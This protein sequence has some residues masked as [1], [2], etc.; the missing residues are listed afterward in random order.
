YKALPEKHHFKFLTFI[1]S[2]DIADLVMELEPDMQKEV[3]QK[4]GIEKSSK[5]MDIMDNDDLADLLSEIS[6]EKLEEYLSAMQT[7]ESKTVQ[8][9][10][11]YPPETAGGIMTNEFVWIRDYYTVRDAVDKF[12]SFAEY[13]RNI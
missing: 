10:M 9:L 4:L 11:S 2:K 8:H 7:D 3:L 6:Q 5:I 1:T 13:T 12:K